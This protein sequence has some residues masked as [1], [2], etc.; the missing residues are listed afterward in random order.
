MRQMPTRQTERGTILVLLALAVVLII[1]LAAMTFDI[2]QAYWTQQKLQVAA[3]LS[4]LAGATQLP[5]QSAATTAAGQIVTANGFSSSTVTFPTSSRVKV[6]LNKAVGY[7]FAGLFGL[8]SKVVAAS[9]TAENAGSS[10]VVPIGLL[11]RSLTVG[12][13]Y[14][15]DWQHLDNDTLRANKFVSLDLDGLGSLNYVTYLENSYTGSVTVGATLN[16]LITSDIPGKSYQGIVNDTSANFAIIERAAQAPWND[17]NN[18]SSYTYP[19]YP[20][21][22]PRIVSVVF[23]TQVANLLPVVKVV[24]FGSFYIHHTNNALD[25]VFLVFLGYGFSSSGKPTLVQ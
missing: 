22:D 14:R 2:G 1:A 3:D 12:T 23:V 13:T 6:I 24:R 9:A 10:P 11:D 25:R 19:N 15:L 16:T 5:D 17:G 4:A 8:T 20:A 7:Q 18:P 21:S